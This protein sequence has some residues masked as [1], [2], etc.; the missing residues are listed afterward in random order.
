MEPFKRLAWQRL[1]RPAPAD[2]GCPQAGRAADI[3]RRL[4]S[5]H[6]SSMNRTSVLAVMALGALTACQSPGELAQKPPTWSAA[7]QVPWDA[8]ANC[9]V[10]GSQRPLLT[11][12]P[13]FSAGR[14]QVVVTNPAGA[15]LGTFDIRQMSG[16]GTEVSY[17]SIYGG[18][19]SGAGGDAR[20]L[21]DRCARP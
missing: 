15:V 9:I 17:R 21:A 5:G 2:A 7:Y 6:P 1:A 11:V 12:T 13:T 20:D 14:A 10:A 8:M 3:E 4:H 16:G 19:G 18:A